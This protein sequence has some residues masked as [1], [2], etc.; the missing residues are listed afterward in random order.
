MRL[1]LLAWLVFLP[2]AGFSQLKGAVSQE[3]L[4]P[5]AGEKRELSSSAPKEVAKNNADKLKVSLKLSN[6]QYTALL[7]AF[8]EYETELAK[9][10]KSKLSKQV[11]FDQSNS[12]S[13]LRRKKM[14]QILTTEQY[15][16]YIMSFP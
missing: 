11:K 6:E 15:Q 3:N 2:L 16:A 8:V 1:S 9:V 13:L 7:K 4:P 5:K 12:L 10:Q 14:K